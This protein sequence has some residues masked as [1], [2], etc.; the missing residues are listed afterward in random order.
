MKFLRKISAFFSAK[1]YNDILKLGGEYTSFQLRTMNKSDYLEAYKGW[2]FRAVTAIAS[3]TASLDF[4]LVDARSGK[5][6]DHGY[7]SLVRYDLIENIASFMKLNGSCFVWKNTIGGKVRSL[8]V[9]RP[10]LVSPE[11]DDT[12]SR[13][14]RY[15]YRINGRTVSFKSDEIL[16]FHNFNPLQAFPFTDQGVGD[17]QAAAVAIDTDSAASVWNWKFFENNAR[18]GMILE[19]DNVIDH[20]VKERL[21]NKWNSAY[22]GANNSHKLVI[23]DGGLKANNQN[24]SQKEMDFVEQRRFSRD[25]ILGIFGVP[26]AVIGLG[27]SVNVGNVRAFNMIFA[28]Q[29][30]RPLAVKIQEVLNDGLF[31]DIG[32]FEF[33]N[34]FP[35]DDEETRK[36][37]DSGFMTV[38]EIRAMRGLPPVRGGDS[39]PPGPSRQTVQ[40]APPRPPAKSLAETKISDIVRKSVKG[41]EEF[42][43]DRWMK[44]NARISKHQTKMSGILAEVFDRQEKDI[45]SRIKK[46]AKGDV[47]QLDRTKYPPIYLSFLKDAY[48]ELFDEEGNRAME[49]VSAGAAFRV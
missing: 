24:P 7:L 42:N 21:A 34:I 1:R 16:A 39:P 28:E 49:E 20:D 31:G 35:Y 2:V 40:D 25:E 23:L 13:I 27:E 38:N 47:P 37:F 10:D 45:L 3:K 9:L 33:I 4:H 15:R 17:V 44:R 26:K 19:T 36:D 30:I 6:L 48:V 32:Y 11:Y 29:T 41:T 22:K 12:W 14:A 5:Q 43:H 8:H 46:S 18:P